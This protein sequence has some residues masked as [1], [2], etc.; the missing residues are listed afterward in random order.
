MDTPL[1]RLRAEVAVSLAIRLGD[2]FRLRS[3]FDRRN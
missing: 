3:K 1:G 2:Q